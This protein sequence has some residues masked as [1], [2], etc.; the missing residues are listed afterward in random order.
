MGDGRTGGRED[1]ISRVLYPTIFEGD[2]SSS[3]SNFAARNSQ[4]GVA[5]ISIR[6]GADSAVLFSRPRYRSEQNIFSSQFQKS[7]ATLV[8]CRKLSA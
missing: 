2:T 4:Q 7:V 1:G 5:E 3:P 6:I 8:E